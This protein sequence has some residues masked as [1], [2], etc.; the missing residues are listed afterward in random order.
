MVS[1][2]RLNLQSNHQETLENITISYPGYFLIVIAIIAI[3]YALSLYFRDKR[4]KENKSWL[5]S[6]LGLL[7]FLT[8]LGILYLLLGP[9]IKHFITEEQKPLIVIAEDTSES[10]SLATNTETLTQLNTDIQNLRTTLSKKYEVIDLT[11]SDRISFSDADTL[12]NQSSNLSLPLEFISDNYEDQNL[13]AVI[14]VTDG[15]YN[16]GKNPLYTDSK[17][18]AP[19]YTIA[20]GDTTIRRDLLIKNVLHNRIVYLNDRFVIETDVQAYNAVG[21]NSSI[22]LSKVTNGKTT[23]LDSKSFKIDKNNYF[24]S[25]SF[26]LAADQIGN[27][28]YVISLANIGSEVTTANNSRNIYVDVL[29]ARQ[30][31][32]LLADSPHPDIKAIKSIVSS[33]KNYTIDVKMANEPMTNLNAYDIVIMHNLPSQK[34]D[35]S[36]Y[37]AQIKK[38]KKPS[39]YIVGGETSTSL[40]NSAQNV[41]TINGSNTSMNEITP[42]LEGGFNLFTLSDLLKNKVKQF[43]PLKV[44]FGE[45]KTAATSKV[46]LYQKIGNVETRYPLLAYS[47]IENHKQ[48][49]LTGEGIWR[50]RLTEFG[51]FPDQPF[52]KETILKTLQYISQKEDKRQ[53]RAFTNKIAYKENENILFDAQLYNAN[54]EAINTEEAYLK[55]SNSAGEKFDYTFSKNNNSYYIDAGRLPEDNYTYVANTNYNGKNITATGKFSVQ[56]IVKEQYDLTAK[57]DLLYSLTEKYGGE[58]IYPA[59][60]PQ[61]SDILSNNE[62]IKPILFQKAETKSLLDYQWLI[63]VLI[64]LLA[65]E[66]FMRRFYGGY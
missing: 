7:R 23:K 18:Q 31:I 58:V 59:G 28:K 8:V 25:F 17:M 36:T 21:A 65:I 32:L 16:E 48:A 22:S 5:P 12:D 19:L 30:K 15:I 9:L 53:F 50:W 38:L 63:A 57:H 62:N 34:Y 14:L 3:V 45:Y 54:Y 1:S 66:W 41:L 47:D 44:P 10:I 6:L 49:V 56:S 11:F 37:L 52:T 64:L 33:N 4:I 61:L 51:D 26:E 40:L 20:L 39:F 35:I 29:D 43:V 55:I 2:K 13:G 27:T 42:I 24:K 60:V 46:L